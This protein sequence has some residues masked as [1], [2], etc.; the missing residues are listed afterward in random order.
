MSAPDLAP[1]E[2]TLRLLQAQQLVRRG[3]LREALAALAPGGTPPGDST[4]LHAL[5]AIIT[6]AGDY[7]QALALW[8]LLLEREPGHA[9]AIRMV[10]VIE[11]WQRRPSWMRWFWPIVATVGGVAVV[12]GL[13]LLV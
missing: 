12:G 7:R 1:L 10:H 11:L 2:T 3:R 8:R 5:A 4:L 13:L 9:E 6:R